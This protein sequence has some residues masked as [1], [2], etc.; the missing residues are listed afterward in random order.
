MVTRDD[1][2]PRLGVGGGERALQPVSLGRVPRI[3]RDDDEARLS[4]RG[5]YVGEVVRQRPAQRG[6]VRIK[7]RVAPPDE[8][9]ERR[10]VVAALVVA[11][12]HPEGRGTLRH[13]AH[14][15]PHLLAGV[16]G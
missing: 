2:V 10:N 6:H 8:A 7:V 13:R 16:R 11:H 15:L 4:Q 5:A 1:R 3:V 14:V 9:R 12:R